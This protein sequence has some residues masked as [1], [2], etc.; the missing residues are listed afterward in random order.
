MILATAVHPRMGVLVNT[1]RDALAD[2][3]NL[4]LLL[5]MIFV[6]FFLI[7]LAQFGG[8]HEH[9]ADAAMTFD[10]LWS[11]FVGGGLSGISLVS[12]VQHFSV[13]VL[14]ALFAFFLGLNVFIAIIV[15]SYVKIKA[16][17]DHLK[18]DSDLFSDLMMAARADMYLRW[19]GCPN[20]A[21]LL[22]ALNSSAK[23]YV[24]PSI[25]LLQLPPSVDI[26]AVR[27]VF[28]YYKKHH[29]FMRPE[30]N[31]PERPDVPISTAVDEIEQ[32]LALML[33]AKV[34]TH[35]ER[36]RHAA[37]ALRLRNSV[38]VPVSRESPLE[39]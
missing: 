22:S 21:A 6:G 29:S 34:T 11:M 26:A 23:W 4:M 33:N 18:A 8:E 36:I 7:G 39:A 28:A 37:V 35:L 27:T 17:V 38:E 16:A 3:L 31:P 32:R 20:Q 12:S 2:L 15:D 30:E 13:L 14:F 9:F 5:G 1:I 24:T 19:H 25:L 10:T